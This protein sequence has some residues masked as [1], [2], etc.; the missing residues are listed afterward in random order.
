MAPKRLCATLGWGSMLTLAALVTGCS[1]TAMK[2]TPMW[3]REYHKAIG[4]AED[5]I[6]VWPLLYHRKPATAVLWPLIAM[7]DEGHAFV[8]LYEY[9]KK[10][11]DLRLGT[12]LPAVPP[13]ARV[14]ALENLVR[15][16]NFVV[17]PKKIALLPL[18]YQSRTSPELWICPALYK[19]EEGFWTPL[20]TR[21]HDF[22]G[23]LGPLFFTV[24]EE[25]F[26]S[27]FC[28][29]P[30]L[31]Y[32]TGEDEKGFLAA[33]LGF[34]SRDGTESVL[35]VGLLLLNL[36]RDGDDRELLYL[37]GLGGAGSKEGK[38][39]NYLAPLWVWAQE[40]EKSLFLSLPFS[41]YR[42]E[43]SRITN[44]LLN[45]YLRLENENGKYEGY[46]AP[47]V[48]R[49]E[50]DEGAG[51][52]VVPFYHFFRRASGA[53]TLV[54]PL[55]GFRDDGRFLYL[56]GPV[57]YASDKDGE[58]WR[59]V[60]WPLFSWWS[61]G[62]RNGS[63]LFPAYYY[64]ESDQ[65]K[66]L[67]VTPLGGFLVGPEWAAYDV[68][69]PLYFSI[70]KEDS[71]SRSIL[72]PLWYDYRDG[73]DRGMALL[74]LFKYD[75][76]PDKESFLSPLFSRGRSGNT[77]F[78]NLGLVLSHT[79]KGED[80]FKQ[81]F[82]A[83]LIGY[84]TAQGAK[85]K[86]MWAFPLFNYDKNQERTSFSA[87][88]G[89]VPLLGYV[90]F[91][92]GR[93][94]ETEDRLRER[95]T[96]RL[97]KGSDR[98]FVERLQRQGEGRRGADEGRLRYREDILWSFRCPL[99]LF[100]V[101]EASDAYLALQD[102]SQPAPP[103]ATIVR[104]PSDES[105]A[106][107]F[108]RRKESHFFPIYAYERREG[109]GGDFHFLWRLYDSKS[110]VREDGAVFRR[111][112]VLGRLFHREKEGERTSIDMFPFMAYDKG[113]DLRKFSFAGGLFGFGRRGAGEGSKAGEKHVKVLWIPIRF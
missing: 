10:E 35:N 113:P 27:Y 66:R 23:I 20:F 30:L 39:W 9:R 37:A 95:M 50:N 22:W 1:A 6:N 90:S 77:S 57:F 82:L 15:V 40:G 13:I 96:E 64:T 102:P 70:R 110:V 88:L 78:L 32:W 91:S 8:P 19:N 100:G 4:P 53:K 76:G 89:N 41:D 14:N 103:G 56:G 42:K 46:L 87:L 75:R 60:L 31:G 45:A 107:S 84:E 7:T 106:L 69:G 81:W 65:K 34:Y 29:F 72:F 58:K 24:Q 16:L 63:Y 61:G 26:Q 55:F 79:K 12:I 54:T 52:M 97:Q 108:E 49:F 99:S 92:Y 112:R 80:F 21:F 38:R 74:P 98:W 2:A 86:K 17:D 94:N 25:D 51:H 48:S 105:L 71:L 73:E 67:L 101:L 44:A 93:S 83:K 47:L 3:D 36:C 109:K 5:R 28:P 18:Y 43:D 11:K 68:L 85:D 59:S 62:D 104:L 111:Q 33:P